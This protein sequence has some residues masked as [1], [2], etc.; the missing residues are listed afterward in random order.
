MCFIFKNHSTKDII[1]IELQR[2][3]YNFELQYMAHKFTLIG[4]IKS[5]DSQLI[6]ITCLENMTS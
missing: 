5:N 3:T 4:T 2:S 1:N 6:Q